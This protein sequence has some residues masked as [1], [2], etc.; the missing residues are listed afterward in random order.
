MRSKAVL[1]IVFAFALCVGAF[2]SLSPTVAA[3]P[4]AASSPTTQNAQWDRVETTEIPLPIAKC[5]AIVKVRPELAPIFARE[6][7]HETVVFKVGKPVGAGT[8]SPLSRTKGGVIP[9]D[10]ACA[11]L[12]R[13]FSQIYYGPLRA[14]GTEQDGTFEY[15]NCTYVKLLP[16]HTCWRN[17]WSWVPGLSVTVDACFDYPQGSKRVAEED[18]HISSGG[19]SQSYWQTVACDI[20]GNF[21]YNHG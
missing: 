18:F 21:S 8:G 6:G 5:E 7:C 9:Y 11:P 12:N 17:T 16:G 10:P 15:N 20:Y 13:S 1:A 19:S 2:A 4:I 3:R 14:W